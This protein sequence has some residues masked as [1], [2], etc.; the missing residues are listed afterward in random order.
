[1]ISIIVPVYQAQAYIGEM[2]ESILSQT[3]KDWE[4]LLVVSRSNDN[5]LEICRSYEKQY[6]RIRVF[7]ED[8]LS[9]S[10]A[11]NK[12][13]QEAKNDHIMFVDSDD[14]LPDKQTLDY[15][16]KKAQVTTADIIVANYMRLWE[17]H[18]LKAKPHNTFSRM[19]QQSEDFR[20]QGFFSVGTLSYVW[21]KLYRKKFL[22]ENKI[23]F[24]DVSYAEDKLFN[25][26][27]YLSG[28]QYEFIDEIGYVYR[29]N[30]QSISHQYNPSLKE[31]WLTIASLLIQQVKEGEK[32]Q[33]DTIDAAAG[34]VE[35]LLIFGIFFAAKMEYVSGK[36]SV[37]AVRKMLIEYYQVPLAQK[38]IKK[39]M[40]EKR[41]Q[42][43]S[44]IHWRVMIRIFSL[45]ANCHLYLSIAIGIRLL[46]MLRID[47]RL[48]DTGIRQ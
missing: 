21:G 44:Q 17:N 27:C 37:R 47:E 23:H 4:V 36:R 13:L 8:D 3:Y 2:L 6:S 28:A 7:E 29:K 16:V 11:R 42:K 9:V 41:I 5:S 20:F 14:Y 38:S 1:M 30:R 45:A 22:D 46:T 34:M 33:S 19:D 40:K 39:C 18:L 31:C 24:F 26:Q 43:L 10:E 12:G 35:Y 15:F 32:K 48:S 25:L